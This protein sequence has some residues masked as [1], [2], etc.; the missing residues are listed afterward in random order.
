MTESG[1]R[2]ASEK[3][4][5]L[6][7][8]TGDG[9]LLRMLGSQESVPVARRS[10][11]WYQ[12]SLL[13]RRQGRDSEADDCLVS[14]LEVAVANRSLPPQGGPYLDPVKRDLRQRL[15][16]GI[17]MTR[18]RKVLTVWAQRTHDQRDLEEIVFELGKLK[19]LAR[20][21]TNK[22]ATK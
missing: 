22:E 4:I 3:L 19:L 6:A 13:A 20:L 11:A 18:Y 2:D 1:W 15:G 14:A 10:Q 16:R 7:N 9:G 5:A 12:A 8:E 21:E 17:D